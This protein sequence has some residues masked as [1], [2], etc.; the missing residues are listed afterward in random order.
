[1]RILLVTNYQPP[2]MGGIEYAAVALKECWKKAGHD[3][4]WLTTDIPRAAAPSA[5]DNVRIPAANFLEDMWQINSPLVNLFHVP[6]INRLID[7]CEVVNVHSLAPGLAS[8]VLFLASIKHKPVVATQ[9][10]G[11]IPLANRMLD[12]FQSVFLCA[13]ARWGMAR[14]MKLTFVGEAVRQWFAANAGLKEERI[15]MT[16]AGIDQSKFY[17][18]NDDERRHLR[19]KWRLAEDR[20]NVLFVGRFYE[21]KGLGIIKQ[22]AESCPET[23][24]TLVGQGPLAPSSWGL[25]N[26]RV[27]AYVS[28]QEL[29]EL[30]GAHDLFIMPSI[31]EGWPAVLPQAMAC[32]LAC[33]ISEETFQ[34]YGRDKN[35][36]IVCPRNVE[37][38]KKNLMEFAGDP[39]KLTGRR[40][41]IAEYAKRHWDWDATARIYLDLFQ[42]SFERPTVSLTK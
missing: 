2:H 10:V 3:V 33:L 17:F 16:P 42:L 29:R 37:M 13:M 41:E 27:I 23:Y 28:D 32:G 14:G 19:N 26:I 39:S 18:V 6:A 21:K 36:F 15:T 24:F 25:A 5:P 12:R 9:H 7:S 31:G 22:L 11:V 1:M 20:L 40:A 8:L 30:Y 35:M 4:V 38:L 34:G